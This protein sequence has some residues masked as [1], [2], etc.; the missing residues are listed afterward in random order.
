VRVAGTRRI[1]RAL[2]AA[3]LAV[4]FATGCSA[5]R[6]AHLYRDGTRALDRGD[7]EAA[8]TALERAAREVPLAS[9]VHNHLGIAYLASGRTE[10]ALRAFE[11][12]V[13]LDCDNEA[14]RANLRRLRGWQI[15]R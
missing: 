9:E 6:G 1:R 10:D 15:A 8:V 13:A 3:A 14:A 11:R 4:F 5:I 12:A 7:A 2:V